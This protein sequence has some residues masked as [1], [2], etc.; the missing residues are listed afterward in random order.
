[1]DVRIITAVVFWSNPVFCK[2]FN[3][4]NHLLIPL[5][6]ALNLFKKPLPL[7]SVHSFN[8]LLP[9][10]N[11]PVSNIKGNSFRCSTPSV[12]L[13]A[14]TEVSPPPRPNTAHAANR[15]WGAAS[16]VV[17]HCDLLAKWL[18]GFTVAFFSYFC[19]LNRPCKLWPLGALPSQIILWIGLKKLFISK[20]SSEDFFFYLVYDCQG[21]GRGF[22]LSFR[23]N[24]TPWWSTDDITNCVI[25]VILELYIW[26]WFTARDRV[27]WNPRGPHVK[28]TWSLKVFV[29]STWRNKFQLWRG[30]TWLVLQTPW[31]MQKVVVFM[32]LK[33]T[34][35]QDE[36]R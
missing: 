9:S 20:K 11:L 6:Y 5:L 13:T 16:R 35:Q 34:H 33:K 1:M 14:A 27:R 3:Q 18:F 19:H 30:Q 2:G 31:K 29:I 4:E 36:F 24:E 22:S 32:T 8:V 28:I 21:G 26:L 15:Q 23:K 10:I 25:S 12:L 17:Q 7:A